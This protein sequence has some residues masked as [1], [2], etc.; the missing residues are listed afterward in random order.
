MFATVC[1]VWR[2][3]DHAIELFNIQSGAEK[4]K[5]AILANSRRFLARSLR[6]SWNPER[7]IEASG[8][9]KTFR[10]IRALDVLDFG[11]ENGTVTALLS[12][13]SAGKITTLRIL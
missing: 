7:M 1:L 8:L 12:R 11:A 9:S 6:Y 2:K 3:A 4:R 5:F 13:N 10:S